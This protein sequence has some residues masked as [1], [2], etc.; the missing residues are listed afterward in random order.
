MRVREEALDVVPAQHDALGAVLQI[1]AVTW[2]PVAVL[3]TRSASSSGA[4]FSNGVSMKP[5]SEYVR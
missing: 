3:E 4:A 2:E 1:L 5:C